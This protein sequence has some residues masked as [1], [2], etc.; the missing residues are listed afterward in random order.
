MEATLIEISWE[1]AN[2]VGGI[3]TVL[4]EKAK[5]IQNKFK[6]NYY[7]IGPFIPEKSFLEFSSLPVPYEFVDILEEVRKLGVE[8]YYGEWL[9]DSRPKCFLID[10]SKF[11]SNVNNLKYELWANYRIDSLRTG[12]DYNHPISWCKATSIFLKYFL[13]KIPTEKK[14]VHLHEWLS[15]AVILF[16]RLPAIT[17]FTTH[18]TVLGRAM[19]E[20]QIEFW[21]HLQLMDPDKESYKF[22][23]EAKHMI[24][25][26]SANKA[27]F[28]TVISRILAIEA[29]YILGRKPN[30][31]LP[32]GIDISKFPTIE[33]IAYAHRINREIIREFVLY[34]FSPY[35]KVELKNS[36][37]YFI[38]GRKEIKNKGI[39][40]FIRALGN[41]NKKLSE[42]DY[43]IFAFIFV[44]S[45]VIDINHTVFH[46]L[47]VYRNLEEKIEDLIPEIK[48][49]LL[50]FLIHK[51]KIASE[52]IFNKDEFD[53]IQ[54]IIKQLKTENNY[55][56]STHI[57]KPNDE[58]MEMLMAVG[59][60]NKPENKVKVIYYPT[61]L[62]KGDGFLNLSYNEVVVGCHVGIFPSFYE[63]WGY[64]PLESAINGVITIT[65]DLT[66]FSDYLQSIASFDKENPGIFI[67]HR[68]NKRGAEVVDELTDIMLKIARFS[69][70]E[71]VQ[72]KLEARRLASLCSWDNLISNYY[73]LYTAALQK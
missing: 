34:F 37:F 30:I 70:A 54:K 49:R 62:N 2:K 40:I 15:G 48:S 27:D 46:N 53:E 5:Y 52:T 23:V 39:D 73:D 69:K 35:Y 32:N 20:S 25:K 4:K 72:N 1:V 71:R 43:D 29:E 8:V 60:D 58:I 21:D 11:L 56:I 14:I 67:V 64:T 36:L 47:N 66:G 22:G 44:P 55:P 18:A 31:I 33:E 38:S 17:I 19:A 50:H 68:K 45:D 57:L 12:D 7:L 13:N 65:T 10:Y 6:N 42:S 9:I 59:L 16:E 61:Y 26:L 24:E 63:P 3:Y 41:L 51:E 28:F